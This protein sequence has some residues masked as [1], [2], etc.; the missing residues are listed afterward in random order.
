MPQHD[1]EKEDF[2]RRRKVTSFVNGTP[3]LLII[4]AIIILSLLYLWFS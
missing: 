2:E 1:Y 3:G 4:F